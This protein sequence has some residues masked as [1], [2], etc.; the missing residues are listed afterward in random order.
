LGFYY[1]GVAGTALAATTAIT[2]GSGVTN[3]PWRMEWQGIVRSVGA[4]GTIMGA[5]E[6]HLGTSV[7]AWTSYP[8]PQTAMA[9]VTIDTTTAKNVTVGAQWGT[10]SASNTL[11]VHGLLIESVC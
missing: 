6:V 10:S 3:V 5:G 4:S 9:A 1:G 11:T 2:T 8:L 7:S